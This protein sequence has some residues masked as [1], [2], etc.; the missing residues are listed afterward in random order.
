MDGSG[1]FSFGLLAFC[2]SSPA[3][4]ESMSTLEP[5]LS[6]VQSTMQACALIG[7]TLAAVWTLYEVPSWHR[8]WED[9]SLL[10]CV[11]G[12]GVT[13]YLWWMKMLGPRGARPELFSLTI[14]LAA[15]PVVYVSRYFFAGVESADGT[16]L[17]V[18]LAG[19][20]IFATLAVLGLK[21]SPWFLAGGIVAHGVGWD[22]WHYGSSTYIPDWYAVGCMVIDLTLGVYVATRMPVY[23]SHWKPAG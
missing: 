7:V 5:N 19:V 21:V 2:I 1:L 13:V 17:R 8:T 18:E 20:V 9:P 3:M 23:R 11:A 6:K 16:W 22:L 4:N 14:F 12:A 10:A 15:M